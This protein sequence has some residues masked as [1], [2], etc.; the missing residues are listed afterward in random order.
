MNKKTIK[1]ALI[2]S[3][4]VSSCSAG[5]SSARLELQGQKEVKPDPVEKVLKQLRQKTAELKSYQCLVEY[6]VN[7]PTFE[8]KTLRKG[9]L[10]Y[11]KAG[12]DSALR[13]NFRTFRQDDEKEEKYIDQYIIDGHWLTK[14]NYEFDGV[15]LTHIDHQLKSVECHQLAEPND[16]NE[17]V[18]AFELVS[19]NFP[20]VGFT[21]VEDLKKEFEIK[22]VEQ[23]KNKAEKFIQLHLKVKPDSVYK[24]DYTTIDFWIDKKLGL[25]ARIVA[26]ATTEDAKLKGDIL[27]LKFIKPKINKKIDEK[28]FGIKIPKGFGKPE[29]FPIKKAKKTEAS[30]PKTID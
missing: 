18:D 29:I 12:N 28:V 14:I 23:E 22:L 24:D 27:Q 3:A 16:P 6:E 10:Y 5:C 9:I 19:R 13:I 21:K 17:P 26:V 30:R 1:V 15:W 4:M 7:Q 25:P 20:I 2:L 8:S 11:K